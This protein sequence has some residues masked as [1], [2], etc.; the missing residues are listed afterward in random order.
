MPVTNYYSAFGEIIGE[1]K[2]GQSRLDYVTD[3]LGSVIATVDQTLTV[4]STARYK[5]Y[6]ADLATTGSQVAFGW[7]GAPGY[8]RTGRI[9]QDIYVRARHASTAE[10]RWTTVDPLWAEELAYVYVGG[11]TTTLDDPSG[12]GVC[13]LAG[14]PAD[15]IT[16][17]AGK[18]HRVGRTYGRCVTVSETI[19]ECYCACPH[20]VTTRAQAVTRGAA[21]LLRK[22]GKCKKGKIG[23]SDPTKCPGDEYSG[24]H[25]TTTYHCKGRVATVSIVCCECEKGKFTCFPVVKG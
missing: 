9:H 24:D 10:G 19:Y 21:E 13:Q 3:A 14:C 7:V 4:K 8:R 2:T 5:P 12:L 11:N 6:G 25:Q 18:C 1:R 20:P 15:V 17:C 16:E 22:F 23:K